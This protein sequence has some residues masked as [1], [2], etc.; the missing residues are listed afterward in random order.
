MKALC[1]GM[2]LCR[3]SL[4][5]VCAVGSVASLTLLD[6]FFC[7]NTLRLDDRMRKKK[8]PKKGAV[9]L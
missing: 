3:S 5:D 1:G 9:K 2:C 8:P 4:L 7:G 6:S